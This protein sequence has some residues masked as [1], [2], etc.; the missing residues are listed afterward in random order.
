[1]DMGFTLSQPSVPSSVTLA[2]AFADI[3]RLFKALAFAGDSPLGLIT[4]VAG[5]GTFFAAVILL[6][7]LG[8]GDMGRLLYSL[9][10]GGG[11]LFGPAFTT[12]GGVF[13]RGN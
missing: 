10:K 7:L 11:L 2:R 13:R 4:L 12:P 9:N 8:G 3:G 1:V 5:E 6:D